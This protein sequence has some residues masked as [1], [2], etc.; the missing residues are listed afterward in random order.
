MI[1]TDRTAP[2]RDYSSS[3][4][5]LVFDLF[6][7]RPCLLALLSVDHLHI[8]SFRSLCSI[9]SIDA[10]NNFL[11]FSAIFILSFPQ[12]RLFSDFHY[13]HVST[14]FLSQPLSDL[15]C[16]QP[17]RPGHFFLVKETSLFRFNSTAHLC[18]SS[19]P[20]QPAR[21]LL[22]IFIPQADYHNTHSPS[23]FPSA[24][25]YTPNHHLR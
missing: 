24:P 13:P 1:N 8:L 22:I 3:T 6:P 9:R 18:S 12:F 5:N 19:F 14:I 15:N 20:I 7:H 21:N 4:R 10:C 16:P 2:T 23:T 17:T 25:P 11:R